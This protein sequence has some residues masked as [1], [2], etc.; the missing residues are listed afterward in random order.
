MCKIN[1]KFKDNLYKN[2][3][4]I[5]AISVYEGIIEN[6]LLIHTTSTIA[7]FKHRRHKQ[8]V[9]VW[10]VIKPFD[11][12]HSH[13][14]NL[15]VAKIIANNVSLNRK[16]KQNMCLRNLASYPRIADESYKYLEWVETLMETKIDK[17]LNNKHYYNVGK[18]VV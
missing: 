4:P 5:T 17:K 14:H 18:K 13:F 15:Q 8:D 16:P 1:K 3:D 2:D 9:L 10:N 11:N 12:G 6:Y 7:V